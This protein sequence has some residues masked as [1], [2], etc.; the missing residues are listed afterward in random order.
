MPVRAA[1]SRYQ[2]VAQTM[3]EAILS[4]AVEPG[5]RLPSEAELSQVHGVSRGTAVKAIEQLVQEGIVTRRQGLGSFVARPALRRPVGRLASFSG[6]VE[7]QGHHATQRLLAREQAPVALARA[8][9]LTEPATRLARLR[10]VDGAPYAIHVTLVPSALV[11]R[12][13]ALAEARLRDP[14]HEDFSL[15]GAFDAVGCPVERATETVS[16]RLAR[17]EETDLLGI[18]P[19]Q[20]LVEVLRRGFDANGRL[21]EATEAV[22][23]SD[24]YRFE[25]ELVRGAAPGSP[26]RLNP[27]G[28]S[29]R[30]PQGR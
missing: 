16:A 8:L 28:A 5:A 30:T 17:P 23:L 27:A 15:Y 25:M 6:G 22:Y 13:A 21:I 24:Q 26:H 10:L 1:P 14:S 11:E 18:Q 20:A 19:P 7:E 3:R 2:L 12:W 29:G 4:G 9:G